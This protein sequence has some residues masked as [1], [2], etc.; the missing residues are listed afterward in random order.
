MQQHAVGG[1]VRVGDPVEVLERGVHAKK[2]KGE[3]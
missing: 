3:A 2:R 1:E